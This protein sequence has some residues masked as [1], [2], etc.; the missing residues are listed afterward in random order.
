MARAG[1]EGVDA[2][3]S[4]FV[5]RFAGMLSDAGMARMPARVFAALLATDSGALTSAELSERLRISPAAVSGAVRYL[6]Q[7]NLVSRE[8]EAG[9]RREVYRIYDDAWYESLFRREQALINWE[10]ALREGAEAL[11]GTPAGARLERTLAFTEFLE[12]EL[13]GLLERWRLHRKEH[14]TQ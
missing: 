8:R 4:R 9:T 11:A 6:N 2:A 5:E 3:V 12:R 1:G 7:V 13:T 10:G 14:F